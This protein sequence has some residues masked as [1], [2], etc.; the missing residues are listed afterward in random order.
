MKLLIVSLPHLTFNNVVD[1]NEACNHFKVS[2]IS[3]KE[4]YRAKLQTEEIHGQ[5]QKKNK[6]Y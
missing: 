3:R 5:L 4:K 6:N 1:N 2:E